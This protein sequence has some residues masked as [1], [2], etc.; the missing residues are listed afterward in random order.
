MSGLSDE[1]RVLRLKRMRGEILNSYETRGSMMSFPGGVLMEEV[2]CAQ[3]M[4]KSQS[5]PPPDPSS[6]KGQ[7]TGADIL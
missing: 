4:I 7:C 2:G 5:W 3:N 6:T 1:A